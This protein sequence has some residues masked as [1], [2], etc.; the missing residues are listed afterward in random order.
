MDSTTSDAPTTTPR[1]AR[2]ALL[3][4]VFLMATS[5]IG[6]GFITQTATYTV[7]LGAAFACAIAISLLVDVA[8][9]M[10]VWRVIGVSGRRAQELGNDVLPGVGWV[11]ALLVVA[12]GLVFNIGNVAGSG[13]G[14]QAMLGVEPR[15]GGAVSAGLAVAVFLSH[16]AGLA[17]DRVVVVLGLLMIVATGAVA[18]TS[19]PPV[20]DV[21][22]QTVAPDTFDVVAVTTIIGGTV[23][24]Y[25]TYAGAHRML[26]SGRTGP[27]HAGAVA[28]SSVVSI[29]V[30]G[31]MRVLLFLAILGV[32]A[33]GAELSADDPAGSAFQ[34]AAGEAGLRVF[35]L[36]LWA[37]ALTS[38]IGA[39][40]T[41]VS[42]L[43]TERTSERRRSWMTVAFIVLS[44]GVF[45]VV[46]QAP[47][48]LL[49]FAGTF[50]GLILPLGFGVLL[51]VAWRRRDLL[52]GYRYP[53]WLLGIGVLAWLLTLYLG[54]QAVLALGDL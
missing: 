11:L 31:V 36:V 48:T 52:Q 8:V 18:V 43:T 34:A 51:Y 38:V 25:I 9:Q 10:N 41:S 5:A 23:G 35:G 15:V 54:Y 3:G 24:G 42:F 45:V 37:A 19:A 17:L 26:A 4:A 49:V 46:E 44:A 21:L 7:S 12:G 40:Y 33:G 29:L 39:A 53:R 1:A 13:L 50:N 6:P 32:V 14:T 30:T 22:R 16:R 20:G 47:T 28:R 2:S 27:E